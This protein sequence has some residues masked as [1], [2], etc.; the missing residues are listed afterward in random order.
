MC[1]YTINKTKN[2]KITF[3]LLI[4]VMNGAAIIGPT[5]LAVLY[6]TAYE[7]RIQGAY[8]L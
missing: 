6:I 8:F 2:N 1:L 7:V 4:L 5:S 3:S